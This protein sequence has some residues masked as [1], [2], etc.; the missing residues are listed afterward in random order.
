MKD[1][2][3]PWLPLWVDSWLFG[4]TRLEL[5]VGQRATFT[6]FLCLARKDNGFIRANEGVPYPTAQL[7][8]L[9]CVPESLIIETIERCIEV[10][11][12]ERQPNGTLY[13]LN[14]EKYQLTPRHVRRLAPPHSSPKEKEIERKGKERKAKTDIRSAK[15]DISLPP[16][17]KNCPFTERDKML[18]LYHG[19][20]E[21]ERNLND[22]GWI[23]RQTGYAYYRTGEGHQMSAE[24]VK[25]EI[26]EDLEK[27]KA[28]YRELVE[29]FSGPSEKKAE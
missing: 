3:K 26:K 11:K 21:I 9:L 24:E 15:E 10:G 25:Q 28:R 22:E 19:I 5:S 12:L 27:R 6:D 4:S 20:K 17:P 29:D 23:S 13:V 2:K 16:I 18:K 7:A 14:W 8:G 1:S